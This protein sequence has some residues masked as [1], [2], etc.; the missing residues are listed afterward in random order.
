[1]QGRGQCTCA[2]VGKAGRRGLREAP[3]PW[4]RRGRRPAFSFPPRAHEI[5]HSPPGPQPTPGGPHKAALCW[6]GGQAPGRA[7]THAGRGGARASWHPS[8]LRGG[9]GGS[10]SQPAGLAAQ[11]L[12]AQGRGA[13]LGQSTSTGVTAANRKGRGPTLGAYPL[14]RGNLRPP[15]A[16][17][18]GRGPHRV[19]VQIYSLLYTISP[20]LRKQAQRRVGLCSQGLA[21]SEVEPRSAWLHDQVFGRNW[22]TGIP[23]PWSPWGAVTG[24]GVRAEEAAWRARVQPPAVQPL[25]PVVMGARR[26]RR[27]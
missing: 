21:R 9:G 25:P 8:C 1:M 16:A 13:G 19:P 4:Q 22:E 6:E 26:R 5:F 20:L 2:G 27:R 3:W 24:N 12:M 15:V 11:G 7:D 17:G 14:G 18:A 23:W 10:P